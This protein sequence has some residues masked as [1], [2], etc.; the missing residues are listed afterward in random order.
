MND[1]HKTLT[2]LAC[3]LFV[4]CAGDAGQPAPPLSD[5]DQAQ[6]EHQQA[7]VLSDLAVGE[8]RVLF[9]EAAPGEVIVQREFP[10]GAE[11]P[12]VENADQLTLEELHLAYAP[13]VEVPQALLDAMERAHAQAPTSTEEAD[14]HFAPGTSG[15]VEPE[16]APLSDDVGVAE[17]ALSSSISQTWFLDN[18]C[19][20]SGV[21]SSWCFGSAWNGAYAKRTSHRMNGVVCADTG[22]A[23]M[24]FK[25]SGSTL[26]L[27]DVPYGW[28]YTMGTYHGPHD[29][30]GSPEKKTLELRVDWAAG[31]VRFAGYWVDN[32][33][34]IA[35]PSGY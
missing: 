9:V 24:R 30:W 20:F 19:G 35:V 29:F 16:L 28:C 14:E 33:R 3:A 12:V 21:S 8:G 1:I 31:R 23:R 15:G 6:V 22:N 10:I 13:D 4:G 17:A 7:N 34:F 27:V 32:D 26:Y 5:D 2:F 11:M 25:R 18:Y